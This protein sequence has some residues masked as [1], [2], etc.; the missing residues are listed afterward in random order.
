MILFKYNIFQSEIFFSLIDDIY[1][2]HNVI[3]Y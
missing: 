1:I 3:A 2:V